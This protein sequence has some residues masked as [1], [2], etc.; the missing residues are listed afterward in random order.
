MIA[1]MSVTDP[2]PIESPCTKVCA[3]D[4]ASGLCVGCLR[5]LAEIAA[6]SGYAP[7]ERARI[8][9]E[10]EGRRGRVAAG[11]RPQGLDGI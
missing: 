4:G 6:W 3:V 9:A 2:P 1:S 10:L 5:T 11:L 8:M 7:A